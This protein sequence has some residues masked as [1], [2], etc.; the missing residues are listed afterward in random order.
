MTSCVTISFL[1][2]PYPWNEIFEKYTLETS[3]SIFCDDNML[4]LPIIVRTIAG[5]QAIVVRCLG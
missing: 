1:E 2:L 4:C 3:E 5:R